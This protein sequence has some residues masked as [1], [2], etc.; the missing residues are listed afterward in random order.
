MAFIAK[1]QVVVV[2]WG[3]VGWGRRRHQANKKTD[4]IMEKGRRPEKEQH[5][6]CYRAC[7]A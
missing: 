2:G 5:D 1:R 3:G 4:S 7:L 6:V